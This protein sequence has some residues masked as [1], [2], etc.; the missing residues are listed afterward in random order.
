[1]SNE[2]KQQIDYVIFDMDGTLIDTE[3]IYTKVTNDILARYGQ[4]MSWSIKSGLMGLPALASAQKLFSCYPEG[5]FPPEYTPEA[6]LDERIRLQDAAFRVVQPLPGA[7]KLIEDLRDSGIPMALATGSTIEGVKTKTSH[8]PLFE[9]F[10]PHVLTSDSPPV[11]PS[12]EPTRGKPAPDIFLA[13]ARS[14]G[15]DVGVNESEGVSEQEKAVRKRGLVFEDALPGVQAALRA[16]MN[17]CWIPD[18]ELLAF[19]SGASEGAHQVL[20]SLEEFDLARWGLGS[21]KD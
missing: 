12:T 18:P 3:T 9:H 21:S 7:V 6:Y 1:M 2:E 14:L 10:H 20:T 15:F 16:G 11:A 19:N 4:T 13:A 17:V 5:T 8:L